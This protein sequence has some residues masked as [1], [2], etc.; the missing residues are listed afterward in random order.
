MVEV[1]SRLS[2]SELPVVLCLGLLTV[3]VCVIGVARIA[4]GVW[5]RYRERRL[6]TLLVLVMLKHQVPFDQIRDVVLAMDLGDSLDRNLALLQ[7]AEGASI[8][9]PG[10]LNREVANSTGPAISSPPTACLSSRVARWLPRR[11]AV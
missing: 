3:A 5:R 6:A 1:L 2:P 8:D 11:V 9:D 10:P 4:A 7:P